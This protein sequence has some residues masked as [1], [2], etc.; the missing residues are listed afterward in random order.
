MLCYDNLMRYLVAKGTKASRGAQ[1]GTKTA[2]KEKKCRAYSHEVD[3][4]M[5]LNG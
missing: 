2:L 1:Q 5:T 3:R 4:N